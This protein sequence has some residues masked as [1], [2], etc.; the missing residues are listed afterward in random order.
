MGKGGS[1]MATPEPMT[2]AESW[3]LSKSR[4]RVATGERER[5]DVLVSG[6]IVDSWLEGC[7]TAPRRL[8]LQVAPRN[9]WGPLWIVEASPSLVSDR[10]WL[11]DLGENLCHGSL[12][13]AVGRTDRTGT[14]VATSL[15]LVR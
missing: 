1:L 8:V 15:K 14:V 4:A 3:R 13:D 12:V 7:L 6:W 10:S 5:D 9:R 11:E 2:A